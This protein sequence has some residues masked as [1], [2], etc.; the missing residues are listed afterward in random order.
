MAKQITEKCRTKSP[1]WKHLG[2]LTDEG[3]VDIQP[4]S[5]PVCQNQFIEPAI[6]LRSQTL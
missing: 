6:I 5:G 3:G 4:D 1:V 2:L